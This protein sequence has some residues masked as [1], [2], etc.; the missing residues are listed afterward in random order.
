MQL[1]WQ[2]SLNDCR[3][4]RGDSCLISSYTHLSY[5]RT[6]I[7]YSFFSESDLSCTAT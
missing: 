1:E 5:Y 6:T 2:L 7:R 3:E 4:V